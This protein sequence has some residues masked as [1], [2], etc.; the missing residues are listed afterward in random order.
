MNIISSI[1]LHHNLVHSIQHGLKYPVL[2][3]LLL[4]LK[5]NMYKAQKDLWVRYIS[6]SLKKKP[7]TQI[8]SLFGAPEVFKLGHQF[9]VWNRKRHVSVSARIV[10]LC[11]SNKHLP[12]FSGLKHQSFIISPP[13]FHLGQLG[14]AV[15]YP[16][17]GPQA[18]TAA[19]IWGVASYCSKGKIALGWFALVSQCSE[20]YKVGRI[21]VKGL[22]EQD[23]LYE[24][25]SE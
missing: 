24:L 22:E 12:H 15:Y 16:Y 23:K 18:D 21:F 7:I 5:T 13:T 20:H 9:K 10:N 17:S 25:Q 8:A 14:S 6:Q 11:F 3:T 2:N 1:F 19:S 4:Y